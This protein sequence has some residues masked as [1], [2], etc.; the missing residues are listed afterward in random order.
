MAF[1]STGLQ[2]RGINNDSAYYDEFSDFTQRLSEKIRSLRK[3]NGLTQEDMMQFELSLRQF[4]RIENNETANM[5]LSNVF[6]IA[7]AFGIEP[8]DLLDI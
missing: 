4:Q 5:T 3:N 6:K 2:M 7:K 1:I 8:K